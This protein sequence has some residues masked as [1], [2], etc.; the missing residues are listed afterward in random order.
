MQSLTHRYLHVGRYLKNKTK[1]ITLMSLLR[2]NYCWF[3]NNA[4]RVL[5]IALCIW[6]ALFF[7]FL[8]SFF[9]NAF[10]HLNLVNISFSKGFKTKNHFLLTHSR[11]L[12]VTKNICIIYINSNFLEFFVFQEF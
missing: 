7:L 1:V 4:F 9:C 3:E 6:T 11:N 8:K 12:C 10:I 5:I 2:M